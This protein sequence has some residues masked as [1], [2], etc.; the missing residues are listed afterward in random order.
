MTLAECARGDIVAI[1]WPDHDYEH[2]R[3]LVGSQVCVQIGNPEMRGGVLVSRLDHELFP[4]ARSARMLPKHVEVDCV[5]V[6]S[7]YRK[8]SKDE[9][10]YLKHAGDAADPMQR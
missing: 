7:P 10:R 2:E 9:E 8:L 1:I 5:V 6:S 4:V 3:E